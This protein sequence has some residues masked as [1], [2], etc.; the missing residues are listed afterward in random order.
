MDGEREREREKKGRLKV[1]RKGW[2]EGEGKDTMKKKEEKLMERGRWES[3][4]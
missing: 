1:K 3:R 2:R 4:R